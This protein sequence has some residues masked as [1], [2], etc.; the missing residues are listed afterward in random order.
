MFII[1]L[2][3]A[4]RCI[5]GCR[6]TSPHNAPHMPPYQHIALASVLMHELREGGERILSNPFGQGLQALPIG[7]LLVMLGAIQTHA[8]VQAINHACIFAAVVDDVQ[9]GHRN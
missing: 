5:A 2:I 9:P 3:K 8:V 1:G 7:H 6:L 4:V